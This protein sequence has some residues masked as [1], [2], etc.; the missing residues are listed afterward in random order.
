MA[1][2][3]SRGDAASRVHRRLRPR[4]SPRGRPRLAGATSV[5]SAVLSSRAPAIS[6]SVRVRPMM[7]RGEAMLSFVYRHATRD[8]TR[9]LDPL[10]AGPRSSPLLDREGAPS[11][12]HATLHA[13]RRRAAAARQQEG[14][15]RC[16]RHA[17]RP[18][19]PPRCRPRRQRARPRQGA[20]APAARPAVLGRPRH[21]RRAPSPGAVDGA[22]VAADRQVPRG[23]GPCAR[24]LPAW[25]ATRAAP[26]R[27]VDFGCGKGYL[28][29]AVHAHLR[30]RFGVAPRGHRRRAARRP[31]R[32]LQRRRRARALRRPRA[33][34]QGD[35]RSFAPGG[36]RRD[37]RAARLRHRDRPCDRPRP[38]RRR[39]DPDLLAVLPQGA[40]AA[41]CAAARCSRGCCAT[42]SISARRPRW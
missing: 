11:F 10:D 26:L 22:Q 25:T 16:V 34:S 28:T 5:R 39:G 41:D 3:N 15:A 9:N 40:A 33:S 23:A 27:V 36:G 8:I 32:V 6:E 31:G 19:P 4:G 24:R 17:A 42:A 14:Q 21:H 35:L 30:R 12:A 13:R 7:L 1:P 20:R 29:F 18:T 2:T 37:D 38:A